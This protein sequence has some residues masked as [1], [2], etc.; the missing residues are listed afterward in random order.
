MRPCRMRNPCF[1][2][3]DFVIAVFIFHCPCAQCTKVRTRIWF[4]K[5][6]GWK[7]LTAGQFWQPV[8][9]LLIRTTANDQL[10]GNFRAR[11]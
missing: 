11:A 4:G 3:S 9:F 5:D 2:T 6:S 10:G 8:F 1:I 7:D